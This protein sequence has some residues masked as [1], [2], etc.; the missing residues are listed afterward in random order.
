MFT[1]S[2]QQ[3]ISFLPFTI[4][5]YYNIKNNDI[6]YPEFDLGFNLGFINA[7][8]ENCSKDIIITDFDK[9]IIALQIGRAH[10]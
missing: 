6:I 1:P 9:K 2:L 3:N 10:V 5:Q 8:K 4:K 7:V